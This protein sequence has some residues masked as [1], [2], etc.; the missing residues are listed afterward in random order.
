[1]PLRDNKNEDFTP[2]WAIEENAKIE[3]SKTGIER[4]FLAIK[5]ENK[6]KYLGLALP[7]TKIQN[8]GGLHC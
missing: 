7:K 1:M 6:E 3:V 8:V 5:E 4:F 2:Q